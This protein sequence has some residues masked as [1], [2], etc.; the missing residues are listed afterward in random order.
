[1]IT[2]DDQ[3]DLFKIISSSMKKDISCYA[4]GGTAMM[5]YGYKDETKDIDLLFE[6]ENSRKIFIDCILSQ[7]FKESSPF[8][9]YVPE[10]LC[11]KNRLLM[12]SRDDFRFDL[13]VNKIFKTRLSP[14]MKEDL[15]AV[16]DYNIN[17]NFR[18]N[19]LRKEHIVLLKAATD[20]DKDFEDI[21]TILKKEKD[22]DWQYLLD[23]TIWQSKNGNSWAILDVEKMLKELKSYVFV[24]EKYL[25]QLY[26]E[27][28]V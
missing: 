20:R 28:R 4:F 9:I 8:N 19:V 14:R 22:F 3:A 7:G 2:Y 1:M 10:K 5:F 16:Q 13:F 21:V 24:P 27:K 12:F 15:F 6:D 11:D 23:E 26:K 18:V 17:K 25:K